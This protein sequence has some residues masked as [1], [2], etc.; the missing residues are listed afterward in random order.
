MP[1]IT[2][3]HFLSQ[4]H[5]FMKYVEKLLYFLSALEIGVLGFAGLD[6]TSG[7]LGVISL[8]FLFFAYAFWFLYSRYE[9]ASIEY[10]AAYPNRKRGEKA[11][12]LLEDYERKTNLSAA[13]LILL[14]FGAFVLL[15][16][17]LLD[18]FVVE[19]LVPSPPTFFSIVAILMAFIA[20]FVVW[21]HAYLP[22]MKGLDDYAQNKGS[23]I[24]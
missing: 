5:E 21:I 1:S 20:L 16:S 3:N 10:E 7:L 8:L 11:F 23:I 17:S 18:H 9:A 14:V 4:H 6:E 22:L 19:A 2:A 12:Y 24:K 13:F 15:L